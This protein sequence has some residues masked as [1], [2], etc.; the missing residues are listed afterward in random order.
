MASKTMIS[1][2]ALSTL[3]YST[4][5]FSSSQLLAQ[6]SKE[7]QGYDL[8]ISNVTV[9]SPERDEPL[10]NAYVA[11]KGG[12]IVAI[13][14]QSNTRDASQVIDG[15]GKFLIPGLID[16]HVHLYHATGLKKRY[17][18][19]FDSLYKNYME[20]MPR[21]FLYHGFTTVIEAY[22]DFET[23]QRFIN[24]DVHPD[25]EYCEALILSDGFMAMEFPKEQL[26]ERAPNFLYDPSNNG[27]LPKDAK[28]KN[29]TPQATVRRIAE[30][31]AKCVKLHYEEA[32][33]MQPEKR[34]FAQLGEAIVKNVV[35]QAHKN[36]LKVMLHATSEEGYLFA[37]KTGVDII[38]HGPWDWEDNDYLSVEIPEA[39]QRAATIASKKHIAIQPTIS[40]L[41]HTA[42]LFKPE[43][44]GDDDLQHVISQDYINYLSTDAQKQR[45]IFIEKFGPL[46]MRN[47]GAESIRPAMMNMLKR[48]KRL[49]GGMAINGA[50]LIFG[51]DTSSGGFG[52][53][54]PPGLNGYWELKDWIDSGIGLSEIFKA[55]TLNNAQAFGLD[56]DIGSIELGKKANLLILKSNPLK[57]IEAYN[58]IDLV[59]INGK[60]IERKQLSATMKKE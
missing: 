14:D 18:K 60:A 32:L 35:A 33:W 29:H 4:F 27:F 12:R 55:S 2:I 8:L 42:S 25:L 57:T 16:S 43:L 1:S 44:L 47:R 34:K 39:V 17:T 54:N 24:S 6:T 36:N 52:W 49:V 5:L 26:L 50:K 48:Y 20:Q 46:V 56:K 41:Q 45:D 30:S 3:I 53:G 21:S 23:N 51:S 28:A 22:A 31:G 38:S 10:S 37:I 58:D 19:N 13:D 59:L 15:T 40:A 11:I 7:N 9:L